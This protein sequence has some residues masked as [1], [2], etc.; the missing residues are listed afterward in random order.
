MTQLEEVRAR[1][2]GMMRTAEDRIREERSVQD[3]LRAE[4][5]TNQTQIAGLTAML[6][7]LGPGIWRLE[8]ILN[9]LNSHKFKLVKMY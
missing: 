1:Q 6:Q 3:K 4:I 8:I 9:N 5:V 7:V 2:E